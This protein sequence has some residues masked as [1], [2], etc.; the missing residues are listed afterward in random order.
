MKNI[1]LIDSESINSST[2]TGVIF[3][4]GGILLS[5]ELEQLDSFELFCRNKPGH[6]LDPYSMWVNKGFH[7]M[8]K[9]NNSSL[10]MW[11]EFHKIVK[12]WQGENGCIWGTY[13]GHSF[14]FPFIEK[15]NY[16]A[17]LPIYILKQNGNEAADFLPFVRASK[18]F[19]PNSF[20][21]KKTLKGNDSFKLTDLAE[22]NVSNLDK[23]TLHTAVGDCKIVWEILKKMKKNAKPVFDSVTKT[24][25][26]SLTERAL[27]ENRIFTTS[28]YWYGR[29]RPT[30]CTKFTNHGEYTWPMVFPLENDPKDLI[31]LS[32]NALKDL[33]KKP[34]KFCRPYPLNKNNVFLHYSFGMTLDIYK[35][36][37][38]E[39]IKERADIIHNNKEFCKNV[40]ETL[41]EIVREKKEKSE[42]QYETKL[43][44]NLLYAGGFAAKPDQEKMAA[45]H[46]T[47]DWL[48]RNK[49]AGQFD[50]ER[51]R[52]LGK[53]LIYQNQSDALSKKEYNEIHTDIARK[54][55][56]IEED[57]FTTIPMSEKLCDDMRNEK[58]ISKEKLDYINEIDE[59][60]HQ[61]RRIY[62]KAS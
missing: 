40:G 36:L 46:A 41:G 32:K 26:K 43:I 5:P 15:E 22:V 33:L 13:N 60:L 16:R 19:F 10:S 53:R 27:E 61:Q 29:S 62:E 18:I 8:M 28:F 20:K 14:D 44:E 7:R 59:W 49:I 9:S 54:I 55:L 56:N 1:A 25:T 12:K 11:Y 42:D 48:E 3:S 17:L 6:V 30:I 39:K 51:F 24:T 37:G 47:D 45:F 2:S 4:L 50:D 52:Y 58:G 38:I 23:K 31:T 35:T 34:G 21:T 57:R